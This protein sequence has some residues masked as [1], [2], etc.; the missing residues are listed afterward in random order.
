MNKKTD[1]IVGSL[2]FA[3]FLF[4][5]ASIAGI[6]G[7]NVPTGEY[8]VFTRKNGTVEIRLANTVSS[9]TNVALMCAD[10]NIISV[11]NSFATNFNKIAMATLLTAWSTNAK[12]QL[13][14]SD[15]PADEDAFNN[16]GVILIHL[17]CEGCPSGL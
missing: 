17:Q 12:I 9:Y 13:L 2:A 16:C 7:I 3:A 11:G 4:S 15:D 10:N 5:Q 14:L 1:W 6:A 8:S